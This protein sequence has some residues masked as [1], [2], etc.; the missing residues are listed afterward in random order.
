[1]SFFGAKKI[2]SEKI[3]I[4]PIPRVWILIHK[5]M[6]QYAQQNQLP[7]PPKPL[8]LAGWAFSNDQEKKQ[9][10]DD[11]VL[12]SI[13]YGCRNFIDKLEDDEFYFANLK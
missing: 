5:Q 3:R 4:C 6:I 2:K 13:T 9:R 12:Y 7:A 1:M 8:I 11:T 10:W